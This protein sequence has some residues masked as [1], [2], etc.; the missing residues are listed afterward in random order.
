MLNTTFRRDVLR[1]LIEQ[2]GMTNTAIAKR[3]GIERNS[4]SRLVTGTSKLTKVETLVRLAKALNVHPVVFFAP[5]EVPPLYLEKDTAMVPVL[6]GV[7]S[8]AQLR[9]ARPEEAREVATPREYL[10]GLPMDEVPVYWVTIQGDGYAPRFKRGDAALVANKAPANGSLVIADMV[11]QGR[12][13]LRRYLEYYD[14][15]D[16]IREIPGDDE[17]VTIQAQQIGHDVCLWE[18]LRAVIKP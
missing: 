15:S 4:L 1:Q 11:G 9:E 12:L 13:L 14:H 6:D 16:L 3:A 7:T 17:L 2:S 18:V 10:E 8:L 5:G